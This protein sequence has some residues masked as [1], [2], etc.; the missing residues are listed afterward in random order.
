MTYFGNETIL[1]S[2]KIAFFCP[3][4]CPARVILRSYE[5][6][7]EQRNLGNCVITGAQTPVEKDVFHFLL[8]GTQPL[9][10]VTG[11]TSWESLDHLQQLG[12]FRK[13]L[14]VISPFEKSTALVSKQIEE[15]LTRYLFT[16]ADE[17]VIAHFT[18]GDSIDQAIK[19]ISGKKISFIP[20]WD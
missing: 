3:Q 18:S 14:L 17:I 6:A 19:K 12:L 16:V 9:I 7:M 15:R 2:H 8:K 1:K 20:D 5:W 10:R 4:K 13:R 11:R